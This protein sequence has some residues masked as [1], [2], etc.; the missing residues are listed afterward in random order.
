MVT[1]A[2]DD[3][4]E[5]IYT[6]EQTELNQK[7][8]QVIDTMDKFIKGMEIQ[9]YTVDLTRELSLMQD[10]YLRKDYVQLADFLLY[11]LKKQFQEAEDLVKND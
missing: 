5:E 6:L 4:V 7:F 10:I 3:L 8:I 9:G 1:A 2:I 11:D